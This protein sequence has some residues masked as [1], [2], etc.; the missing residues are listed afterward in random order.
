MRAINWRLGLFRLWLLY[1]AMSIGDAAWD[2][3]H[4]PCAP[5]PP[6]R[7][8]TAAEFFST[9]DCPRVVHSLLDYVR[10]A[11]LLP[12]LAL[13]AGLVLIW[14]FEGFSGKPSGEKSASLKAKARGA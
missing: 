3:Y 5:A 13:I 4:Q 2:A 14:V 9:A 8:P 10:E 11:L 12:A 7:L 6:G 1:V